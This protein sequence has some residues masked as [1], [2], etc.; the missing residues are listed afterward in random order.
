MKR[1]IN[2]A[3]AAVGLPLLAE[4]PTLAEQ[5]IPFRFHTWGGLFAPSGTP[6]EIHPQA[7]S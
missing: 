1:W 5:D 2:V 4:V 3:K 7:E 6:I